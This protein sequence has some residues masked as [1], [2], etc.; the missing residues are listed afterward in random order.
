MTALKLYFVLRESE[1]GGH[2][3]FNLIS[4]KYIINNKQV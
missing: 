4:Q 1:A 3:R 2:K